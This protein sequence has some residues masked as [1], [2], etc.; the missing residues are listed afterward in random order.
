MVAHGIFTQYEA[1][2]YQQ[3][4]VGGIAKLQYYNEL[5]QQR[6]QNALER[7]RLYEMVGLTQYG[8]FAVLHV[9][10][11]FRYPSMTWLNPNII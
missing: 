3:R 6:K 7:K 2:K 8:I 1:A 9:K 10:C 4:V 11:R 5:L